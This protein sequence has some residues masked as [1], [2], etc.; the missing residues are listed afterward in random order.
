MLL[1]L[2]KVFGNSKNPVIYKYQRFRVALFSELISV[3]F[4]LEKEGK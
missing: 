1:L 4:F 3:Y 2:I